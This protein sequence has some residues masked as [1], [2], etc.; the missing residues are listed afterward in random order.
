MIF[1]YYDILD[2]NGE[3]V[4]GNGELGEIIEAFYYLS[5]EEGSFFGLENHVSII[6]QFAFSDDRWIADIPRPKENGSF[7]KIL[8]YE[9]C[10]ALIEEFYNTKKITR[11]GFTFETYN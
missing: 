8:D 3:K 5:E 10:V 2:E 6:L 11:D 9:E 1:W 4:E 7:K